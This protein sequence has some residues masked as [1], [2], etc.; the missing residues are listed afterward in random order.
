MRAKHVPLHESY[1]AEF[2]AHL[3][4]LKTAGNEFNQA[5]DAM[6]RKP[7][8]TDIASLNKAKN[9]VAAVIRDLKQSMSCFDVVS[10]KWSTKK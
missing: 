9:A 3:T 7:S 5:S 8:K 1:G 4:A 6:P 10:R 2:L